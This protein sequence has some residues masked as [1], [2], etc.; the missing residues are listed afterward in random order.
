MKL[1]PPEITIPA[2]YATEHLPLGQKIVRAKLSVPWSN[3][4]W[5]VCE[6]DAEQ[7]LG[8]GL[9]S[10]LEDEWGYFSIDEIE[11]LRGPGGLTVERDLNLAP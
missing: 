2:L 3:W 6:Y 9:V 8:W 1:L 10:G 7:H 5:F 4:T 11:A